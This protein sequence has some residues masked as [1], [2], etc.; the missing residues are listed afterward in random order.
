VGIKRSNCCWMA[1]ADEP[2]DGEWNLKICFSCS[3]ETR[4]ANTSV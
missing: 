3:T 1:N 2:I 4:Q